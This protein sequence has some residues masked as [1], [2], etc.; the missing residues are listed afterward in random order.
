MKRTLTLIMLGTLG[1]NAC[2]KDEVTEDIPGCITQEVEAFTVNSTCKTTGLTTGASV[3]QYR[4]QNDLVYVF[5]EGS[6]QAG[7]SLVYNQKCEGIGSLGGFAGSTKIN[8]ES[9][10]KAEFMRTIWQN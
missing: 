6:C 10:S 2:K 9:F 3:K 4:F 5:D 8:G 1:L 7:F